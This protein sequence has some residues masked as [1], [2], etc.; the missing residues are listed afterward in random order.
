M[1]IPK[2]KKKRNVTNLHGYELVDDYSWVHQKNIL[3]VLTNK[4]KLLPEVKNY[5]EKE[6]EYTAFKL[7]DTDKIQDKLFKEIKG[8]IKLD[9]ESLK[10]KDKDYTYWS[11]YEKGNNYANYLRQKHSNKK[12]EIYWNG[13]EEA[14]GKAFF[15]LGDLEVS[16]DD[17]L[18]AFSIDDKGSELYKIKIRNLSDNKD[19]KDEIY[20]TSGSITWSYD[21]KYIFYSK[22]DK[23][24][25]PRQIY[26]HKIGTNEKEDLL[27]YEEK[28]K[29]FSC[30]INSSSD[31]K[32][33]FISTSDH[34]T[35]EVLF[36]SKDEK[37]PNPRVIRERQRDILYSVNS[38]NNELIIRTNLNALDFKICKS[39]HSNPENWIDYIPAKNQTIIGGCTFLNKWMIRS[40]VRNALSKI[41]V[42]NLKTEKE[43]ELLITDEVVISPTI[44]LSQKDKNTDNI[45]IGYESPKTPSRTYLYNI[46]TQEKKLVKEKTIPSGHNPDEYIVER[47]NAKSRDN[48]DIPL[49][50]TYHKKTRLNGEAKLLLYGYGSYG[51]SMYPAFSTTNLSLINRGI[52]WVTAHIRGG[53]E[54]GMSW[55]LDGKMM[56]KKNTFN[57]YID[58]AEFLIKK[59]YTSEGNIIGY[60][61]SAGG[62]LMGAVV[63]EKPKL[64]LGMIL[65]VPFVDS[66]TTN[67]DHSLPLTAGEFFEFG[68]AKENKKHFEYILSYTPY[69]NIKK[70]DYPNML[71][72][73][74]LND[75][76][77]LFDEPLKFTA[78]LRDFK[79]DKNLLLLKTEME[80][81]HG[82]KSGRDA[83]IKEIAFD[84]SFILKICNLLST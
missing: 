59:K 56:N 67:L 2:L 39:K 44:S 9:D 33:Y 4:N 42:R 48:K 15:N 3:E 32:Y 25:R 12:I 74:S 43:D 65:A 27:I 71:I 20:H 23:N 64:F 8:R 63:N 47:V 51:S 49:T 26:R 81:G 38:W 40:E 79:T 52:I 76:R 70:Q 61:G 80:A 13:D 62:L 5:L 75:S 19:L 29:S 21:S 55:W 77:V 68:N 1:K 53:S 36:F 84:Y 82:G 41:L 50:I 10:F 54:R 18:L 6:N 46:S 66:L 58:S 14:K 72:T 34:T 30:S 11:K 24:H 17:K 83:S 22:R 28:D 78:K 57:D 7:K 60:G 73:T 35:S 69:H 31:E 45:Y 37:I 16:D